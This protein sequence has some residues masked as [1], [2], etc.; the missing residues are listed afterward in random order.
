MVKQSKLIKLITSPTAAFNVIFCEKVPVV[1][2]NEKLN[3]L[4]APVSLTI[5]CPNDNP[6]SSVTF[7]VKLITSLI[8]IEAKQ[9]N[10]LLAFK[11]ENYVVLGCTGFNKNP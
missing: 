8:L 4:T 11:V 3:I 1:P 10:T 5:I 7:A 6:V 2:D 9:R